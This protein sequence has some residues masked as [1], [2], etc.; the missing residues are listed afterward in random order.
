MRPVAALPAIDLMAWD[1][2]SARE[3]A[4]PLDRLADV[5]QGEISRTAS[6]R[7]PGRIARADGARI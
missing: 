1:T 5:E 4:C 7:Q 2:R 3:S 6:G